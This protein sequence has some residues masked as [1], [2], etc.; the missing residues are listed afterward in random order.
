MNQI[1]EKIREVCGAETHIPNDDEL[2]EY[3]SIELLLKETKYSLWTIDS[4]TL[5]VKYDASEFNKAI[6]DID[7][8]YSFLKK[9][10]LLLRVYDGIKMLKKKK[11][12]KRHLKN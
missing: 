4:L 9:Q 12:L 10:I 3:E 6:N 5:K 2:G 11:D 8:R 7:L 1:E